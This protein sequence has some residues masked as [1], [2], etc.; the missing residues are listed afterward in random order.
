MVEVPRPIEGS[1]LATEPN[2]SAPVK[3]RTEPTKGSELKKAAEQPKALSPL[4]EIELPKASRI[5]VATPRKRRMASVL[6]DVMESV[7][8]PTSAPDIEG[9]VLK[10]SSEAGTAQATSEVGPSVSAEAH[11]SEAASL[12]LEKESVPEK[13]KSPAPE[14]PAEELEFIVRHASRKQLSKEQIAEARQYAKDLK[15]P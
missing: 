1:S 14:T 6:D 2:R 13:S 3:A 15:Y 11:P 7:K 5:P 8:I 12:T 9:E 10:K 4:R